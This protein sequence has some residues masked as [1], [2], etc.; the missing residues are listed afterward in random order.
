MRVGLE[1]LDDLFLLRYADIYGMHRVPVSAQS[2]S[3]RLLNELRERIAAVET[4][5]AA[6]SLKDLAVNGKDLL[7]LGLPSG[8]HIGRILNELFQCVLDAPSMNT[9]EQ[10][11]TVAARKKSEYV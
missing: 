3:V 2:D 11:L 10:L 8:K 6:L 5:K 9:R 4:E 7:A 1:H